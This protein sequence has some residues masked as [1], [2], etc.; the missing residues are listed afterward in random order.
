ML[1]KKINFHDRD[2]EI[3]TIGS[4]IREKRQELAL[5][6]EN[7]A[8]SLN[9]TPQHISAI[10]LDQREPSLELLVKIAVE[11]GTSTDYLLTGKEAII[12]DVIPTIKADKEFSLDVKNGLIAII[13]AI[14]QKA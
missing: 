3:M 5:T 7:L 1:S 10:E 13:K 2:R 14:R 12:D 6:Q 8:N 4:R 9:V 11:L